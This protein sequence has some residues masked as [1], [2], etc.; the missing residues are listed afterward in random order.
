MMLSSRIANLTKFA[1]P[2]ANFM[3][4]SPKPT[5]CGRLW[6]WI[7]IACRQ[8]ENYPSDFWKSTRK[9]SKVRGCPLIHL[10]VDWNYICNAW[11][12][13]M[14]MRGVV[15]GSG[16]ESSNIQ[17]MQLYMNVKM[18]SMSQSYL[19]DRFWTNFHYFILW[20]FVFLS[21]PIQDL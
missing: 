18:V 15:L 5:W 6:W 20:G 1:L 12:F 16:K 13:L 9:N 14:G 7:T 19:C 3:L 8:T 2:K 4:L 11:I 17:S 10:K 21:L